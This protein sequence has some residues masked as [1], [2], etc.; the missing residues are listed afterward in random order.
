MVTLVLKV[1]ITYAMPCFQGTPRVSSFEVLTANAF[2]QYDSGG[3]YLYHIPHMPSGIQSRDQNDKR[4]TPLLIWSS[5]DGSASGEYGGLYYDRT[6]A[7]L[8]KFYLHN[9]KYSHMI[10]FGIDT[11]TDAEHDPCIGYPAVLNHTVTPADGD[12][13]DRL[14]FRWAKGR[15]GV[16]FG[17][18]F[19]GGEFHTSTVLIDDP[20]RRGYFRG[21]LGRYRLLDNWWIERMEHDEV[22]GRIFLVTGD[23]DS[24]TCELFFADLPAQRRVT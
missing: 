4:Q 15:R 14:S 17:F 8:P 1:V 22:T 21:S 2:I 12:P 24:G 3:I 23:G 7:V 19:S 5:Y 9:E 20:D 6:D 11:P 18:N 10:E 16:H 13:N